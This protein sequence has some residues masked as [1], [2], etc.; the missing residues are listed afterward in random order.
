[1][2]KEA[3]EVKYPIAAHDNVFK[4]KKYVIVDTIDINMEGDSFILK[5]LLKIEFQ[6]SCYY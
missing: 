4:N 5:E 2:C 3:V 1:M 6:K